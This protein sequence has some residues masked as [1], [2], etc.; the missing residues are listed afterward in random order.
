MQKFRDNIFYSSAII[1]FFAWIVNTVAVMRICGINH[2]VILRE[3]LLLAI[4]VYTFYSYAQKIYED[5]DTAPFNG[6]AEVSKGDVLVFRF[7]GPWMSLALQL[8]LTI[9]LIFSVHGKLF[10]EEDPQ[11]VCELRRSRYQ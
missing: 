7:F 8:A 3:L 5:I 9:I 10:S 2:P 11:I 1:G 4:L 6:R